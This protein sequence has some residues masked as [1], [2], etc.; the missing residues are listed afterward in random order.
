MLNN[1]NISTDA[2][3][4]EL[5]GNWLFNMRMG[6]IVEPYGNNSFPDKFN[7]LLELMEMG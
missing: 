1:K 7:M 5:K 2:S 4:T 3:R 6:I